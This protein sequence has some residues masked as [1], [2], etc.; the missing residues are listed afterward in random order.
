MGWGDQGWRQSTGAQVAVAG[1]LD[2]EQSHMEKTALLSPSPGFPIGGR[3]SHGQRR[4]GLELL[5]KPTFYLSSMNENIIS[6]KGCSPWQHR[7]IMGD[8]IS[9]D[10]KPSYKSEW[11]KQRFLLLVNFMVDLTVLTWLWCW[12]GGAWNAFFFFS[13]QFFSSFCPKRLR[14]DLKCRFPVLGLPGCNCLWENAYFVCSKRENIE[15]RLVMMIMKTS[16]PQG[17]LGWVPAFPM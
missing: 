5:P 13:S 15:E 14:L 7:E 2:V 1:G 12:W 4:W 3:L 10:M 16:H 17:Q 6:K 9:A 8:V 11:K